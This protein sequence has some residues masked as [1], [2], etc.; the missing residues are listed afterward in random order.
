MVDSARLNDWIQA[1][2]IFAVVASLVFVGIE[3]RQ[4][5]IAT[6]SATN[7][8]V[9][10]SFREL[11]LAIASSP[12]LARAMVTSTETPDD[13]LPEDRLRVLALWRAL[14]HVWSNVHRQHLNGTIDP[15]LY[16]AVVQEISAYAGNSHGSV[17]LNDVERRKRQMRWA[18]ES[19]R[20]LFNP[21]FQLFVD[22]VIGV[23]R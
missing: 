3:V 22:D 2:G 18:W 11:N 17:A 1:V 4:N 19:E 12:E 9:K 13:A 10:D 16:D 8:A 14:F 20:F 21:D 5:S 6:R 23:K 15:T 7:A